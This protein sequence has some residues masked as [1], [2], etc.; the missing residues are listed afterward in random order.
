MQDLP[1]ERELLPVPELPQ[2][3][4]AE[5]REHIRRHC[6]SMVV[7]DQDESLGMSCAG[8]LCVIQGVAGLLTAWHVWDRLSRAQKLVLM[9]GPQ[10]PYRIERTLLHAYAPPA[11]FGE[12]DR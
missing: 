1:P 4:T 9:L 5:A 6:V 3:I 2:A 7:A 11:Y 10:H 12:R 8:V